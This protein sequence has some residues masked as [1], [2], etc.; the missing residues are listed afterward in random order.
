MGLRFVDENTT[1]CSVVVKQIYINLCE[2]EFSQKTQTKLKFHHTHCDK[3]GLTF[4]RCYVRLFNNFQKKLTNQ[5]NKCYTLKNKALNGNKRM[6]K[7]DSK[8]PHNGELNE[9]TSNEKIKVSNVK[10]IQVKK[11]DLKCLAFYIALKQM[12]QIHGI[13]IVVSHVI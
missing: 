10:H 5:M 13:L 12:N 7:N 8:I 6:S 4:D 3:M 1:S 9:S 2:E 11:Y